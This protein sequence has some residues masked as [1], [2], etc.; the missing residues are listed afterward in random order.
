MELLKAQWLTLSELMN[1]VE[2]N[3]PRETL[4]IWQ[5]NKIEETVG[6]DTYMSWLDA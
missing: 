2:P 5:L 6:Y 4:I 1:E 3:S